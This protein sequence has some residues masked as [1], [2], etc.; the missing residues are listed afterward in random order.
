MTG[1]IAEELCDSWK[2][3]AQF[4]NKVNIY[5]LGITFECCK[6]DTKCFRIVEDFLLWSFGEA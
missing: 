5:K 4:V 2:I 3:I 1:K 6:K